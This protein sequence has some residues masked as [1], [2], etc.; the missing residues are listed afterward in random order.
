MDNNQKNSIIEVKKAL[1]SAPVLKFANPDRQ[2]IVKSNTLNFSIGA[3]LF[4]KK[5]CMRTS[6]SIY[7]IS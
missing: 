7:A 4:Q 1:S 2:F 5:K 6:K 3:F